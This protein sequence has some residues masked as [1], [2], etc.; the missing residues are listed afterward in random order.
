MM[1]QVLETKQNKK[2]YYFLCIQIPELNHPKLWFGKKKL[3]CSVS[4]NAQLTVQTMSLFKMGH[5]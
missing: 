4:Y 3:H 1:W 5:G 2:S